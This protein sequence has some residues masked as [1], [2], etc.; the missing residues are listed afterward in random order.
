MIA[1]T[2]VSSGTFTVTGDQRDYF[3]PGL[4]LWLVQTEDDAF[5]DVTAAVYQSVP[6]TTLI[7]TSETVVTA[8]LSEVRLG[9]GYYDTNS[10]TGNVPTHHH[11]KE[12]DGGEK[13]FGR[14]DDAGIVDALKIIGERMP[15]VSLGVTYFSGDALIIKSA[16]AASPLMVLRSNAANTG[17]EFVLQTAANLADVEVTSPTNGQVLAYDVTDEKWKNATISVSG[18]GGSTEAIILHF[19]GIS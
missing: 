5:C 18:G 17:F 6:D 10:E 2:Y 9:P 19:M 15:S 1:A 13:P 11:T 16:T 7:S 8:G 3:P 4:N 12:G 14:F